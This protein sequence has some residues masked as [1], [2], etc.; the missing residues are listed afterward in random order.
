M[1][2]G[3]S[4]Q[5]VILKASSINPSVNF[6]YSQAIKVVLVLLG[7]IVLLKG[8]LC[9]AEIPQLKSYGYI[10]NASEDG[11]GNTSKVVS[12]ESLSYSPTKNLQGRIFNADLTEEFQRRYQEKFGRT[13]AENRYQTVVNPRATF[14][15]DLGQELTEFEVQTRQREY[16]E[17]MFRRLAEFHFEN[18]MKN[19]ESTRSVWEFKEKVSRVEVAVAPGVNVKANYSLSGNLVDFQLSNPWI[20]SQAVFFLGTPN[21]KETVVSV[22]RGLTKTID[23]EVHSAFEDGIIKMLGRKS[24]SSVASYTLILSTNTHDHGWSSRETL[25][26][27]GFSLLF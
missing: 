5:K 18:S 25:Y 1:G 15:N 6:I 11:F 22:G 10:E 17:Y 3:L 9:A 7:F 4:R 20:R 8:S 24:I 27:G 14:R 13:Q 12:F 2:V 21:Q 26:L 19:D 16:G 23:V